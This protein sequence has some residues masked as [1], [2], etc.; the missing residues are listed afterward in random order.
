[1]AYRRRKSSSLFANFIKFA[2]LTAV[3]VYAVWYGYE[4]F[5]AFNPE[6]ILK[7]SVL[8]EKT[9]A[10]QAQE[11]ISPRHKI[12]AYLIED[13]TN[14]IIS[15]SFLFK[16]G[17]LASDDA[18]KQG[19]SNVVAAMLTEGSGA[20]DSQA[21]KEKLENL[22]IGI[23]FDASLD[24]FS[25]S[26][27]TT[28]EN[29]EEAYRLLADSLTKPL[30]AEKDLQRIKEQLYQSFLIQKEHPNSILNLEFAKYLYENH[31][32]GRNPLGSREAIARL[33]GADL[34]EFLQTHLALNNLV[35]GVAGNIDAQ[36]LGPVLDKVFG[37]LPQNAGINFVRNPEVNF[38]R[39]EK[40]INLPAAA[41][42]NISAFAAPGVARTHKDFYPLYIANHILGGAGLSSRLSKAARE[43]KGLTYGIY[44]YLG[45]AD[46]S[47]LIRGGFSST[48]E[49]YDKVVSILKEEWNKFGREGATKQEAEDAKNYLVSSYNL[50]F[51]SVADLSAILLYMQK[52]NLGLDFLQKRNEYIKNV[53]IEEINNAARRYFTTENMISVNVG[54]F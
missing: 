37:S 23:S 21:F 54:Q 18:G 25:G 39:S 30:F 33:T 42:Q 44:S 40:N 9:F 6:Q 11:V 24:D 41:G 10:S 43:D 53:S 51:A 28:S 45:L 19:I 32:Y 46:K 22:A 27:I 36:K 50:R 13:N 34:N 29:Q 17:G 12:K 38:S 2:G 15:I 7:E 1:M 14:P 26:L 47:P 35:I 31:P 48:K 49:N 5:V 8:K 52:D 20:L 16:N 4:R 3:A